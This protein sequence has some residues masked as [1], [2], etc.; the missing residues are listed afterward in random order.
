MERL[1]RELRSE[2]M[3]ASVLAEFIPSR[4]RELMNKGRTGRTWARLKSL[5]AFP[6]KT[7]ADA[8]LGGTETVVPTTN[9]FTLPALMVMSRS[10][11]GRMVVPLIYDLYP[12]AMEVAGVTSSRGLVAQCAVLLNRV[13]IRQADGVVFIGRRM[14]EHVIARYGEPKNY[15]I[16]ETGADAQ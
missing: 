11:H 2:G 7:I 16:I 9:P 15:T 3:D 6:L 10:L 4:W 14:A 1:V 12:D 13:M 5:T 8:T